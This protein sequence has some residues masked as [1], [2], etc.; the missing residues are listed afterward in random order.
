[1]LAAAPAPRSR[2]VV[3]LSGTGSLCAA[4]LAATDEPG[5]P[6]EVV[7]VG[8]DRAAEGLEHARRR[9]LPTF[10]CALADHPDRAA[11]DRALAGQIAAHQPDLVVSAGFMKL[12][13]PAVL[14]AFGGRLINTHPAL[15][16]A[17][18]GAHA[19]RDA[20]AAGVATTGAT[21]HV[22]DAGLDTGPVLAQRE[23]PVLP[24]DDEPRLH[25]RIKDVERE[26]LVHTV[27]Q[28][29]TASTEGESR[30]TDRTP[31]RR[32]LLGV[33]DKAGIED[34]AAG[35]A[36]AGVELV[37]TGATAARI[38]AA[39]VPVTPVE[40]VTGFPECLD[41]RVKTLHPAV[42]AGILADRRKTEH[43]A[44]LEELGLAP[45]DLVVVNLYP[46]TETV[47]SGAAPEECVEQ[48]DIGG[49]AMVRAAAKNHPSV[50][51]VV[52]P[53][54][55]GDVLA[56]VAAGGFTLAERQK[57]AAAAFRH[58]ATYDA[59]VA[60]WMGDVLAP[61]DDSGFPTWVGATW[62]RAEVLRY[63]ENP[64]QRAALY[65]SREPGLAHAEQL[66]G[67]QM[68][69]N[70]YIDTD[71]AWRAA[72]DHDDPCVAIIKHANPCGIAVGADIAAAHRK[73]HACDPLSAFGG[74]IA[75]NRE[76]DL[77]MAEQIADVFTEVVVAPSFTDD[78]LAMLTGKKNVRLLRLPHLPGA[79]PELR[80]VGGGLLLQVRDRIDAPGDDPT[81]WTLA[82]GE[83]LD[84][85]GL[86]DL[87]F[88]W[89]AVRAVKSN[90]ILL[91][92]DRATVGVGMGQVNR[93]DAARLAVSRAG[94]RAAG[95]V[96]ASDAFFPFAD[97]LQV[98]LEADVRAV[99][100][101]GGSVRDEEVVA[102]AAAAGVPLY[103][104]GTRH[105]AH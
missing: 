100:Q 82:A 24:G 38:A 71:A 27:A 81:T 16:P 41:G 47:A 62:D 31:I 45:F 99:V 88:A 102:A 15:L 17:F 51:V 30:M 97:G 19:V 42:H 23:V 65:R 25:E 87:V 20:L 48:I 33:Y 74:V 40:Q 83:P 84:A 58:T 95:S 44:Q 96:A 9:G 12:V 11:W 2:V 72:H 8:A 29:V 85:A 36:A 79:G 57:L 101:P 55:Y 76:V 52:D 78:A 35:L 39:G 56:A 70:N 43:V 59:G 32:A 67:K 77:T 104:T 50:A 105:F 1:V 5:Y 92:H 60:S 61:D 53:A 94:E 14:G 64:H 3:L 26:L 4:L 7:A 89:R 63:G 103:L 6:A 98:L 73:A 75:A 66:H 34:L 86:D 80:P 22:V 49:P 18:P 37:S 46:F 10:V 68:S 28:L 90:A 21:V 54:R 13:G 69:Y 91:A 93:V